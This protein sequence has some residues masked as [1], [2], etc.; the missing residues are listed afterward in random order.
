MTTIFLLQILTEEQEPMNTKFTESYNATQ[1]HQQN[2]VQLN[3]V[4]N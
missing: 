3:S 1:I 2:C 4:H